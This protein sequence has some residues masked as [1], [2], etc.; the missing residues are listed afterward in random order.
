MSPQS[1]SPAVDDE[2]PDQSP[3][4]DDKRKQQHTK[5]PAQTPAAGD[6]AISGAQAENN[7]TGNKADTP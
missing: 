1:L 2:D 7:Q 4:A 5:R 6:G 3:V